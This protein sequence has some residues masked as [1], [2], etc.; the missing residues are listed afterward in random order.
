MKREQDQGSQGFRL[1]LAATGLAVS[2]GR[3]PEDPPDDPARHER[4][5][6][7]DCRDHG[8]CGFLGDPEQDH[9]A[10]PAARRRRALSTT[11]PI[12]PAGASPRSSAAA[13]SPAPSSS[14][15]S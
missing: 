1:S 5:A 6:D 14:D 7:R 4:D 9:A 15:G 13:Y 11:A 10:T 8:D 2:F 12:T 3:A